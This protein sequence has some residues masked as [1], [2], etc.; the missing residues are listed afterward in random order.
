MGPS[1]SSRGP[2]RV[3][4]EGVDEAGEHVQRDPD[5][6]GEHYQSLTLQAVKV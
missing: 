3:V 5:V 4:G 6:A 2:E 1:A